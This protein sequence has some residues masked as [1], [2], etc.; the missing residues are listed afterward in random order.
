MAIY[1]HLELESIRYPAGTRVERGQFIAESGNTGYSSGPHLHFA[2]QKNFGM[3]LRSI[4][5]RFQ[6]EDGASFVPLMGMKVS[7]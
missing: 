6:D 5:F 4:P 1:A 7:R 2:V 3:D